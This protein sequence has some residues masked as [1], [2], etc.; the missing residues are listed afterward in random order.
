MRRNDIHFDLAQDVARRGRGSPYHM[1]FGVLAIK[2]D[3]I[4]DGLA[5]KKGF[6]V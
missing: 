2:I 5:L 6:K 1:H 3:K 4:D